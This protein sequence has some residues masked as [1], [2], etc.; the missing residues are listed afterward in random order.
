MDRTRI[1]GDSP[2]KRGRKK[3]H[4]DELRPDGLTKEQAELLMGL[5]GEANISWA[6]L[7]R[8]IFKNF[9][10][11]VGFTDEEQGLAKPE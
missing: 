5:A 11:S 10:N 1:P 7:K 4:A 3:I 6:A 9:L 2:R 8:R